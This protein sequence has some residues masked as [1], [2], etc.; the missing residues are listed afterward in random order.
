MD[1]PALAKLYEHWVDTPGWRLEPDFPRQE[2]DLRVQ[3]ARDRMAAADLDAL[4]ITTNLVGRWFTSVREPHEWHDLCQARFAMYVLTQERDVLFMTPSAGGEHFNTTRRST[5]VSE[6]RAIVERATPPRVEIWALEQLPGI[7][8]ELGLEEARIGF[9]LGDCMTLGMSFLDFCRLKDLMPK[10]DLVDGSPVIRWLMSVLTPWELENLRTACE[11]AVWIHERVPEILR[12]GMTEREF[13]DRLNQRVTEQYRPPFEY[14]HAGAWDVRNASAPETSNSFHAVVTD[15]P[16]MVGDVIMR[17]YSGIAY[18]GYT[19]DID[20]VW[21]VGEPT[22]E[23]RDLYRLTWECNRAMAEVL[24]PG[25]TCADVYEAGA[26]VERRW[27]RPPR[28]TGRTGHGYRNTGS[29]SV[30]PDNTIV[31]EPGMVISVEPMFPT[32]HGFFDLEDQYVIT[33]DGALCLHTPAP[34]HLPVIPA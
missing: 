17:G 12:P 7:F 16:F 1:F 5:H 3:R 8:A 2:Y 9:E 14:H 10:A 11:A 6:I 27:G 18:R 22:P 13:L 20:R 29:L 21:V 24:R 15:R 4:V 28:G 32:I 25:I 26:R 31:L 19:A 34:E 30:H 33:E 23:V